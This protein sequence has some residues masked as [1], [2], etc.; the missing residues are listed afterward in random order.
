MVEDLNAENIPAVQQSLRQS[1]IV[2]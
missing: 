2:G 1:E